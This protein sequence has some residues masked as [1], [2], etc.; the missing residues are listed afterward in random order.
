MP[1]RIA[2]MPGRSLTPL[3]TAVLLGVAACSSDI[4]GEQSCKASARGECPEIL[5]RT[6]F[7]RTE[8]TIVYY[9][10]DGRILSL[11]GGASS[12]R[13]GKWKVDAAGTHEILT[14]PFVGQLQPAPLA[15]M[16]NVESYAGDPAGVAEKS[17]NAAI[18]PG[19]A[20]PFVEIAREMRAR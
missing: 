15:R 11:G 6:F 2:R 8:G 16:T 10:P 20:R 12:V 3:A 14:Y 1:H 18:E 9:H 19:D 7:V 4:V 17:R 13:T 5:D